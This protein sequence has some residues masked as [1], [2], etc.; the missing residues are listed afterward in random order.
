MRSKSFPRLA[1]PVTAFAFLVSGAFAIPVEVSHPVADFLRRL[2]EKGVTPPGFWSTLP[3]DSREVARTLS[4][5]KEK[6]GR[7]SAWDR[8]RLDRYLNEFDPVL[9]QATPLRYEDSSFAVRASLEYFTGI[10]LRDSLPVSG[11]HAFGTFSPT[12]E[13]TT[14]KTGF[15]VASASVSQERTLEPRFDGY[16]YDPAHGMPYN[17]SRDG[18]GKPQKASSFDG[19]R[20]VMGIS[21]GSFALEAG[22]DWNQWGPG[23]WQH[24][25]LGARPYFWT[26]DSLAP[27]PSGSPVRFPGNGDSYSESRRGY[28]YPGEAAPL[29]QIRLRISTA[30]FEYSK[31]VA[32][33]MGVHKDSSAYLV[34]HRVQL[35]LGNWKFGGTEMLAVGNRSL[36]PVMLLPGVPLKLAEHDGGDKDNSAMAGDV[37]WTWVGVGR[38]YGELM[39]DDFSGPPLDYWGNKFSYVVGASWQ[40]PFGLPS[41]WHL[42]FAHVDPYVYGHHLYNSQMQSYGAL[43]GSVLPP[44]SHAVFAS[45][46]FP[47]PYGIEGLAEYT[48]RQRD[49]KSRGSSIFHDYFDNTFNPEPKE[50]TKQFL[51]RDVETRNEATVSGAWSWKRYASLKGGLGGMWVSNYRGQPGTSLATP[52]AFVEVTLRY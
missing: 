18:N 27:S 43:L 5:A 35:R 21:D 28:R 36:D 8:R 51:A 17:V 42:E 14:G 2:E 11:T 12:V 38:V 47:L 44:N 48:F 23:H 22:Q 6:E 26:T 37:E 20:A 19:F 1:G 32:E 33:R 24:A 15:L 9:R 7:L 16:N 3:R 46:A 31:V 39:L 50:S 10:Y 29:P 13:L 40:D 41:E 49:S 34:A 45:A 30:R 25:T 4:H 52:T